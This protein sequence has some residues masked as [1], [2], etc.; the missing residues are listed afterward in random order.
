MRESTI[1]GRGVPRNQLRILTTGTQSETSK[2]DHDGWSKRRGIWETGLWQN[3][4]RI[5]DES[6][7]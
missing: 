3:S 4:G 7:Q 1:T 6:L 2:T 5:R